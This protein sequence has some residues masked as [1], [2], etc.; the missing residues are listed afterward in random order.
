[1]A[2]KEVHIPIPRTHECCFICKRDFA[3]VIKDF[4]MWRLFW[5][6]QAGPMKSQVSLKR[7]G[8]A[9]RDKM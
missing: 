5:I 7:E 3:D 4:K 9:P 6:I 1:M 8:G 2:P